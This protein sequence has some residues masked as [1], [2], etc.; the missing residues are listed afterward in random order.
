MVFIVKSGKTG[1]DAIY[2]KDG[3]SP[4][5]FVVPTKKELEREV[6]IEEIEFMGKR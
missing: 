3:E 6:I 5:D 4:L 1:Y 2:A